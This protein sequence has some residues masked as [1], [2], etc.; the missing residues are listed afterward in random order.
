LTEYKTLEA[1]SP[2]QS[3]VIL[4]VGNRK[5][6]LKRRLI[7]MGLTPGTTIYVRKIAPFGDPVEVS[8]R[9][10]DLSIRKEDLR[11][12][13]IGDLPSARRRHRSTSYFV[14]RELDPETR[15]RMRLAHEHEMDAHSHAYDPA[16]HDREPKMRIA[17][18][19][20]PNSGK[21]TLFNALTGSNQS[22]GNWP[23]VTVEKKE[24]EAALDRHEITIV[25]LPGVYSLSPYSMEEIVARDYI[26]G[27]AGAA[28]PDAIINIVDAT[29]LERNLYLTVQMLELERP[30]VVAL[31]F[32]DE[33][34]AAGDAIDHAALAQKLGIPVVPI[35]ARTGENI[36]ELLYTAHR[37]MHIGFTVEP[38]DLY[39]D[40]THMIHHRID[41]VIH[42]KAHEAGLPAHWTSIKLLE[43]DAAVEE[44]LSLTRGE[45][46]ELSAIVAEF[47]ELGGGLGDSE[48]LVANARYQFIESVVAAA[49]RRGGKSKAA[50]RSEAIDRVATHK[51]FAVPLF[52]LMMLVM[53]SITFGPAGSFLSDW[54]GAAMERAGELFSLWL[55]DLNVAQ[56][57][58][59][60]VCDGIIAG[61][62]GVLT[63]LPQIALLFLCMSILE[64]TG[65]M[66]RAAFIMDRLL[67]R[68]GLS[69]KA[70]IPMLMGFGCSVPAIMGSRTMENE[71]D[72]RMTIMLIPFMSCSAKLPVYGL[73][74]AAFFGRRAGV[75][76]FL[77][78]LLGMALGIISGLIFKCTLFRGEPAAFVME[79]PPY[80]IPSPRSV[81]MHVWERVRG[82][83][84]RAGTLILIMSVVLWFLQSFDTR[85][86]YTADM[87]SSVLARI[88]GF[89]APVFRP[90]GFGAW[91][92][93]VAILTG[94]IA[95]EAV[96]ASIAMFYGFS[97][98]AGAGAVAG[99]MTG[100]TPASAFSFLV[101]I[102]LYVPCVAA[103]AAVYREMNSAKWTAALAAWQIGAAWITSFAAYNIARLVI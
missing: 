84:V 48:T 58:T 68:F 73:I 102:L 94:I 19:G 12:I 81:A 52:L 13:T 103:M 28:P 10:Y 66:A 65:Y 96:V 46:E 22:V 101:F 31:N 42:D 47:E 75:V 97:L 56:W 69:G 1:L 54:V 7:D 39:D 38:D 32:M 30:M 17:L 74:A 6:A 79:L 25:D 35:S 83:I 86:I 16:A 11:Q 21:T 33:I 60:L 59:A 34:R 91:Q 64:D 57:L 15:R 45:R 100:F 24:G 8:V 50:K 2:G 92:A 55:A 98:S 5:S 77:L 93:S 4:S 41:A 49:A 27:A 29:N 90:L 85:L 53:F 82:F 89:F 14:P 9:G 95:K 26:L 99:A 20:N 40:F 51:I 43:G 61:V 44:A 67:R 71:K 72:R 76:I 63:F 37:Q 80:R 36:E 88:G 70:F 18:A 62:G 87:S 78:Y 3:A 23:G